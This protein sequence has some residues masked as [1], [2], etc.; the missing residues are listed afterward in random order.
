M[1]SMYKCEFLIYKSQLF[2]SFAI[3]N[4]FN[5]IINLLKYSNYHVNIFFNILRMYRNYRNGRFSKKY[6]NCQ[7]KKSCTRNVT[8]VLILKDRCEKNSVLVTDDNKF[9]K[10]CRKLCSKV[11]TAILKFSCSKNGNKTNN[12][13][14]TI[15]IKHDL[16]D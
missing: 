13:E 5:E 10:Y 12:I 1:V 4:I 2:I 14:Y 6:L 15:I 7:G 3:N 8:K 11:S 9:K 16:L